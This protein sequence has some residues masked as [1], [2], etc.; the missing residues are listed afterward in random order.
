MILAGEVQIQI[1]VGIGGVLEVNDKVKHWSKY[2]QI[3]LLIGNIYFKE[4]INP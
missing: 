1:T 3:E 4:K 2:V